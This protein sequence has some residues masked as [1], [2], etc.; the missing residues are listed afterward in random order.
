MAHNAISKTAGR[1]DIILF[2]NFFFL[3]C[4]QS[5]I[6]QYRRNFIRR[7]QARSEVTSPKQWN[8]TVRLPQ[9]WGMLLPRLGWGYPAEEYP[10]PRALRHCSH[11]APHLL[12]P[13]HNRNKKRASSGAGGA[14]LHDPE[15]A[16]TALVLRGIIPGEWL[17]TLRNTFPPHFSYNYSPLLTLQYCTENPQA[18]RPKSS[19]P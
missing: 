16:L 18:P 15:L 4:S 5:E 19:W 7:L 12:C 14:P 3:D 1:D 11:A 9:E 8:H 10:T 6:S 17:S 13:M 2:N